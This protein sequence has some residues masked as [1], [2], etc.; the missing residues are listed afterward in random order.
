MKQFIES[1]TKAGFH[2]T[3]LDKKKVSKEDATTDWDGVQAKGATVFSKGAKQVIME[4]VP[5]GGTVYKN[6][7][8]KDGEKELLFTNTG[9]IPSAEFM[10][11]FIS[12]KPAEK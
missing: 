11:K 7:T 5:S 2:E 6:I 1:L 8:F 4:N 10:E 3:S 12:E 9:D